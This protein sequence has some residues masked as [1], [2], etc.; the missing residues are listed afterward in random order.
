MFEVALALVAIGARALPECAFFLAAAPEGKD[1]REGDLALA[2]IV[3]DILAEGGRAAAIVE[4]VVDKLE[5]D[6][7]I[8]AVGPRGLRLRPRHGSPRRRQFRRRQ[9]RAPLSLRR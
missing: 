9:R 8:A 4:S 2:E 7:E 5:G 6:A 1:D 3:S